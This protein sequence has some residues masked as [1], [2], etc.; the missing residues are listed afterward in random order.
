MF[1]KATAAALVLS[2]VPAVLALTLFTG[3]AQADG[4]TP[5][6]KGTCDDT[7]WGR[8]VPTSAA[9][10]HSDGQRHGD[11]RWHCGGRRHGDTPW[12]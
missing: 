11:G 10:F 7:P 2:A 6:G 4:D 1:R 5:W 3:T 12:G 8:S 9:P